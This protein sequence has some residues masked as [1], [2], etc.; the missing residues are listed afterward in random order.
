MLGRFSGSCGAAVLRAGVWPI[1]MA[2]TRTVS[3][4]WASIG[5]DGVEADHHAGAAA[6]EAGLVRLAAVAAFGLNAWL[7]LIELGRVVL[8]S[9]LYGFSSNPLAV[10]VATGLSMPLHLRH[11]AYA[12]RDDRP[13]GAAWSLAA[14]IAV[15]AAA[16]FVVGP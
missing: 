2:D 1:R 3:G 4:G 14:L 6:G 8:T 7:P 12:L 9:E 13:P 11:V 5:F 16:V 15:N 10:L